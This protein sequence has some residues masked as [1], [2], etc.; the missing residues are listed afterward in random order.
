MRWDNCQ[1]VTYYETADGIYETKGSVLIDG[2]RIVVDYVSGETVVYKGED[3]G[4]GHFELK[5]DGFDGRATLHQAPGTLILEGYW[6]EEGARGMWRI[7]L[8]E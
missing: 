5:G 8:Q 2:D 4:H 3:L 6:S 7:H 1:I